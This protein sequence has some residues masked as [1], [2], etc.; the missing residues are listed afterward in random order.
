MATHVIIFMSV[1]G[2][3]TRPYLDVGLS[4]DSTGETGRVLKVWAPEGA[5]NDP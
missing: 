3:L 1:V 2:A 5:Q 4:V